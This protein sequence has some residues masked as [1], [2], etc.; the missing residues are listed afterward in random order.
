MHENE[1]Y[2]CA[3]SDLEMLLF[4]VRTK[5]VVV[6]A[7]AVVLVGLG[8]VEPSLA[9]VVQPVGASLA[10]DQ[11]D[12]ESLSHYWHAKV[13]RWESLI[14]QEATRRKLDPDFVASL[15][16]MESRGDANAVGPV[17]SVGLM[18]VMPKE[19]GFTWRPTREELLNPYTNLFWGTRTL[20]TVIQQGDGDVFSALAAYNGGWEKVSSRVPRAF[21]AT[22][23]HDYARAVAARHSVEGA[24]SAFVAIQDN[25]LH[26]P[27]WVTNADS[28]DVYHYADVNVT[29]EG[30]A[31]IPAVAPTSVLASCID[32]D[33]GLAYTV[34]IWLYCL[35]S[36]QWLTTGTAPVVE[37]VLRSAMASP[38]LMAGS[39][40]LPPPEPPKPTAMPVVASVPRTVAPTQTPARGSLDG[41]ATTPTPEPVAC[42][43]GPLVL[44]TYPL[45]SFNTEAGWSA[46]VYASARGGDCVYDYAWNIEDDVKG[47]GFT[48][49]I[50]FEVHSARRASVI[51]GTVLVTSNNE[52]VRVGLYIE[53]PRD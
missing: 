53:P 21:A 39:Q 42:A 1:S 46:R 25:E 16:W 12:R 2:R 47:S 26:G 45:E 20:A 9:R 38:S 23:L 4:A 15:V 52:T 40:P 34:G 41:P 18:Q 13:L 8:V 50:V 24:W 14:V 37:S 30:N 3:L 29:P 44:D 22:I 43:G 5:R 17:G 6:C 48:G 36:R 35:D 7:L 10:A 33:T 19:A 31:L 32:P 28:S 11:D 51:V 49:P 27:I